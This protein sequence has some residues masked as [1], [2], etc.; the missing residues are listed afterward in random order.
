MTSMNEL[1]Q[2]VV[3]DLGAGLTKAGYAGTSDPSL[4]LGTLVGHPKLPKILP[5]STSAPDLPSSNVQTRHEY[6]SSSAKPSV[7][8]VVGEALNSLSGIVRLSYPMHRAT[9]VDWPAA[10]ELWRHV[11]DSLSVAHGEHPFLVTEAPLNPR[12]NRER[13]AE[14]FFESCHVPSLYVSVPG[15]LS[16][17]ASGRTTGQVLDVG[18]TV[19]TAIP[20]VEGHCDVHAI[21]RIDIGGRDVTER[22]ATLL[23]KSGT[24]LFT[25]SSER[26]AVRRLKERLSYVATDPREEERRFL[27]QNVDEGSLSASFELPDGNK[28]QVGTE[29]FRAPE[30]LFQPEIVAYEFGGVHDCIANSIDAVD[31][32]LRRR[33]YSSILL[34]VSCLW[35]YHSF[36]KY[37]QARC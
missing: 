30:V 17:Y 23:R 6:A 31:I 4:V 37:N 1:N 22:L 14:F 10:E 20:V 7:E 33:L 29:R 26:Q 28:V 21:R 24:S 5:T 35:W 18:D 16:L 27:S 9:V 12:K 19:S 13:I 11:T 2:A 25:S 8:Y 15:I 3:L 36:T 34:A 32:E